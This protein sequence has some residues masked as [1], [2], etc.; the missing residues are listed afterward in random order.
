MEYWK[1]HVWNNQCVDTTFHLTFKFFFLFPFFLSTLWK[2]PPLLIE[3]L[4][5]MIPNFE[6]VSF[7]YYLL[8]FFLFPYSK[9]VK[10]WKITR[11]RGSCIELGGSHHKL[12]LI[13]S[14]HM[15]IDCCGEIKIRYAIWKALQCHVCGQGVM[16]NSMGL[17]HGGI[18]LHFDYYYYFF[19]IPYV[20]III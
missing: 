2:N 13:E 18:T 11:Q 19:T 1:C 10:F 6:N 8:F 3:Q 7:I 12:P 17:Y 14:M 9:Q 5:H 20:Y 15:Q 16:Y 4:Y